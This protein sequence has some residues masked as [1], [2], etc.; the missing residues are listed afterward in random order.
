MTETAAQRPGLISYVATF[1]PPEMLHVYRQVT[2]IQSFENHVVTRH[3]QNEDRFPYPDVTELHMSP[4]RGLRRLHYRMRRLPVPIGA[5]EKRHLIALAERFRVRIFHAYLG[6][7]AARLLPFLQS[8]DCAK[9]VSFHGTD[10]SD[11]LSQTD[12]EQ[13]QRC[14]QLFLVRSESLAQVLIE[15]G[16]PREHIRLTPT[17]IPTPHEIKDS[18]PGARDAVRLFQACRLIS[19]KGL[20]VS[21][22]AL[23]KLTNR[24]ARYTL[25]IAGDG[26]LKSELVALTES[27]GI[28][29]R[30]RWLGFLDN[31]ALLRL[32][33]DY[34]V[35]LHPSRTTK[36]GDREGIPNAM[37]E[38][39]AHGVP[40]IATRHSGIP[41]AITDGEHGLLIDHANAD[42][43]CKQ[44]AWL[45]EDPARMQKISRAA[46]QRVAEN[47]NIER[48]RIRVENCYREAIELSTRT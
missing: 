21:L 20:D 16:C 6:T 4:L 41:E 2:G 9:V 5:T 30:V 25:D 43:L 7:E 47:F 24:D 40:I 12:L 46:A 8:T 39:M 44:I 27:L 10:L 22:Q 15:R 35:F 31:D 32:L 11:S 48:C 45:T 29:E 33:P 38:A 13:L 18:F 3:R 19:K 26:P 37:L 17:G 42:Q 34:D 36:E 1:L 23:A 28:A 14:T